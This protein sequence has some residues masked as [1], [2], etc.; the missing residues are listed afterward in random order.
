MSREE[1]VQNILPTPSIQTTEKIAFLGDSFTPAD[2]PTLTWWEAYGSCE[3]NAL[4]EMALQKNPS[5]Q[6]VQEKIALAKAQA[7]IVRSELFP[8]LYFDANDQWQ[9]LSKN[10]LYRALNPDVP[11]SSSQIDFSL[12]FS[13]EFDFW[14]KHRNLYKA[15]IGREKSAVAQASQVELITATSLS[16]AY[17]A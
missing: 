14:G 9:Y 4:I 15:A 3:L 16:Q 11:L 2:W 8:L 17:F 1:R 10:G 6:A 7:V 12:S 13:Y 5:I